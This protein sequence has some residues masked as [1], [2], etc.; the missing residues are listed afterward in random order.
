MARPW[1]DGAGK[2]SV[3]PSP[4]AGPGG[5]RGR[6]CNRSARSDEEKEAVDAIRIARAGRQSLGNRRPRNGRW[7][8]GHASA[9]PAL[10][11]LPPAAV[12]KQ[13]AGISSSRQMVLHIPFGALAPHGARAPRRVSRLPTRR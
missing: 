13:K 3:A 1:G 9:I 11:A 8:H 7:S 2:S 6:Q 10:A 4:A 12:R 5:S